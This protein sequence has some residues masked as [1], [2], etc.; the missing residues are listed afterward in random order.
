LEMA[1]NFVAVVE[2]WVRL[3]HS[4]ASFA[5]VQRIDFA[6]AA[7]LVCWVILVQASDREEFAVYHCSMEQDSVR[8]FAAAAARALELVWEVE[9]QRVL[10]QESLARPALEPELL[11]AG[12]F[13]SF[14]AG[15]LV[16]G[17]EQAWVAEW[18]LAQ[19]LVP[20]VALLHKADWESE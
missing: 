7:A 8:L 17:S 15:L 10:T 1:A 9:R 13:G 3:V 19:E 14:P 5:V 11:S 6:P 20:E 12:V 2:Q 4:V 18:S 16:L